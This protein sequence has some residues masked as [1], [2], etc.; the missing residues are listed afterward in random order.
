MVLGLNEVGTGVLT[1]GFV[2]EFVYMQSLNDVGKREVVAD[3]GGEN[4]KL[5]ERR[6]PY[7]VASTMT[8]L[9]WMKK[10]LDLG[11]AMFG[12]F[13]DDLVPGMSPLATNS[14]IVGALR[15]LPPTA[16][17]L[18]LEMIMES[19]THMSTVPGAP[20]LLRVHS[21]LGTGAIIYTAKGAKKVLQR[22]LPAFFPSMD[23]MLA[24]LIAGGLLEVIALLLVVSARDIFWARK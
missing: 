7:T 5:P 8:M 4:R 23:N 10:A 20:H 6:L 16:D 22:T 21:P 13:E 14:M 19:C 1:E 3:Q 17:L 18:Y 9:A 24:H 12:I 11:L 15:E 2:S